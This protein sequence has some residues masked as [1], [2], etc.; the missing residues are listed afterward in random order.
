MGALIHTKG[1]RRLAGHFNYIFQDTAKF[2]S[3]YSSTGVLDDLSGTSNL[4]NSP[5]YLFQLSEK[6]RGKLKGGGDLFYPADHAGH[7]NLLKRW[8]YF[9]QHELSLNCNVAIKNAI[10]FALT[11]PSPSGGFEYKKVTFDT[12]EGRPVLDV[13]QT[14]LVS[15]EYESTSD[16]TDND[17]AT[18]YMKIVLVTP[19][20]R[21]PIPLD[22]QTT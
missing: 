3:D 1:T 10:Y 2:V 17:L 5:T 11:C 8:K 15:D 20:T 21:A 9:L 22:D 6:Y 12:V 4:P 19:L 18:K 16:H 7:K 13:D 14:V